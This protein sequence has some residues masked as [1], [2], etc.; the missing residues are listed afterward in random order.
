[1]DGKAHVRPESVWAKVPRDA[2]SYGA[3][4][5]KITYKL[6]ANA[7]NGIASWILRELGRSTTFETLAYFGDWDPRYIIMILGAVK[8]G[9]KVNLTNL[10][11]PVF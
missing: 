9:Y 5:R 4:Y 10:D 2:S 8:A 3:G 6:F 11:G 7:I 1:M